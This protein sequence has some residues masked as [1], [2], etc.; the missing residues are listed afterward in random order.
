MNMKEI[1][2]IN[3]C[4]YLTKFIT[5]NWNYRGNPQFPCP[6]PVSIERKDFVKLKN[7]DYLPSTI[8]LTKGIKIMK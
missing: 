6:Q 8:Q 1:T 4:A 7:Y 3:Y 5:Y 2:N